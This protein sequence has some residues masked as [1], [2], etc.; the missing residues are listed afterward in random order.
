MKIFGIGLN[1]TGTSTLGAAGELLGLRAKSWDAALFRDTMIEGRR[2]LLWR[3]ID[4]F[5]LFNDFPYPL[6]YPEIAERYPDA[7]FVLTRRASPEAWLSSLKAHAMRASLSS[8]THRVVYGLQYPHGF[9][10]SFLD[11]YACHNAA[12][13]QF[14][15][16]RHEAFLEI[17][18]E[19]EADLSR[20]AAFVGRDAPA[21]A[22]PRANARDGKRVN[23]LRLAGNYCGLMVQSLRGA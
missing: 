5:D 20:F 12:A 7:K 14:F 21:T 3:A 11:Y 23:P 18:W 10:Q 22:L 8:R 9:E 4:E 17:C 6:L 2:E 1:K 19:E 16:G 13:R 15:A